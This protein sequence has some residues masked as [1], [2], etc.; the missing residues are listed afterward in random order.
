MPYFQ[1]GIMILKW[2]YKN[3]NFRNNSKENK[4]LKI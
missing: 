1:K 3:G 4:C 2:E